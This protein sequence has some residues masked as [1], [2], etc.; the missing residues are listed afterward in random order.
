MEQLSKARIKLIHSLQHK[1]FRLKYDKFIVEGLKITKELLAEYSNIVES[2]YISNSDYQ[3][4][5]AAL[6]GEERICLI[7][8]SEMKSISQM[9]TPPGV[10][11]VCRLPEIPEMQKDLSGKKIF[12]LDGVRDPGNLGTILRIADWFGMEDMLLSP[13]CA[14]VFNPKVIQ[15]S[16]SSFL[17]VKT[18][19]LDH[20]SLILLTGALYVCHMGGKDIRSMP[21][22]AEGVFVLGNESNGVSEFILNKAREVI[23]VSGEKSLGA[24][25]LNV[26]SVAAIVGAWLQ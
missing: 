25:S 16:M 24:E 19:V 10:L 2:I 5:L 15:A 26:A 20:Q 18:H 4:L 12:Y 17:R 6:A 22:P 13:D 23:A 3:S 7:S 9:S 11:S 1:K 21:P 14:D 8:P